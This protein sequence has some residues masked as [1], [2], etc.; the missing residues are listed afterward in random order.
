MQSAEPDVQVI[1][2]GSLAAHV[3][4]FHIC[5]EL[6][7]E[8]HYPVAKIAVIRNRINRKDTLLQPPSR[9]ASKQPPAQ[10]LNPAQALPNLSLELGECHPSLQSSS[11]VPM[12]R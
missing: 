7:S 11:V 12:P 2:L 8:A 9:N 4:I 1:G 5:Y 6:T 10:T 3:P